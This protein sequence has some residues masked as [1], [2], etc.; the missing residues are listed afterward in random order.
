MKAFLKSVPGKICIAAVAL[1]LLAAL[2]LCGYTFWHY[3]QPKFHDVTV[4]L[5]DDMP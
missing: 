5:G 2:R 3:M 1:V 4:E